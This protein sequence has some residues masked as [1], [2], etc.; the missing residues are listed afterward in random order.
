MHERGNE[1]HRW[2]VILAGGDGNRLQA[3]NA[4]CI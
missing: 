3:I 2:G 1:E 4:S